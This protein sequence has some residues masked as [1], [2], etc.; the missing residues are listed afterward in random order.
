MSREARERLLQI[1]RR[2]LPKNADQLTDDELVRATFA[3][4]E[5]ER[6]AVLID[7]NE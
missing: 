7:P 2:H 1:L 3:A 5:R 4:Y 6:E